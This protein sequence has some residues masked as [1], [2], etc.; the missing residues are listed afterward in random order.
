MS[1][2]VP[3]SERAAMAW[4][5]WYTRRLPSGLGDARRAEL[6]SDLHEHRAEARDSGEPER[7]TSVEIAARLVEG[8][9]A[10]LSWRHAQRSRVR[11]MTM[12]TDSSA[13]GYPMWLTIVLFVM[14][15]LALFMSLS[16]VVGALVDGDEGMLVWALLLFL[17]GASIIGGLLLVD[18]A[19]YASVTLAAVGAVGFGLATYWMVLTVVV[20]V[21]VAAAVLL[22]IPRVVGPRLAT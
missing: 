20:G 8:M 4:T 5:R 12:A 9:P 6:A 13:R 14:G 2:G 15:G 18:R 11:S 7:R 21:V 17:V 19:P 1:T 3:M 16:S 10:D 22:C